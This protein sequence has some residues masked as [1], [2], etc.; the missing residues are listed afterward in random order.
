MSD[1]SV[2]NQYVN[3]VVDLDSA[4]TASSHAATPDPHGQEWPDG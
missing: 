3:D 1:R 2:M 4:D